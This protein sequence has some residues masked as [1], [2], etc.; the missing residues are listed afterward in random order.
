MQ[1]GKRGG[2]TKF[3]ARN[4]KGRGREKAL[5]LKFEIRKEEVIGQWSAVIGGEKEEEVTAKPQRSLRGA[6]DE[7][8]DRGSWLKRCFALRR[9]DTLVV[10]FGKINR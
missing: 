10:L 3:K 9:H 5:N 6:E 8:G 1:D 2:S 7:E 4:S